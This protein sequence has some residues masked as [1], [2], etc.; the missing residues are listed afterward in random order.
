MNPSN[1]WKGKLE[2]ASFFFRQKYVQLVWLHFED[3]L[4][5]YVVVVKK[6]P[7][8]VYFSKTIS[9]FKRIR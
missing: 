2:A 8:P 6:L 4:E 1:T 5:I 9:L 3:F 7:Q